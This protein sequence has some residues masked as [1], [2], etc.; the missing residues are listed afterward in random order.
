MGNLAQAVENK[1]SENGER[2]DKK[3]QV[4]ET[5]YTYMRGLMQEIG[6]NRD[7]SMQ[8]NKEL[9]SMGRKLRGLGESTKS[10]VMES[11]NAL[12]QNSAESE[13]R[14]ETTVRTNLPKIPYLREAEVEYPIERSESL[15]PCLDAGGDGR[16]LGV[17]GSTETKHH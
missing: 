3:E 6:L 15:H 12:I 7:A 9:V 14:D 5:L 1:L 4:L 17:K 10:E 16:K 8:T 2:G 13:T 11:A